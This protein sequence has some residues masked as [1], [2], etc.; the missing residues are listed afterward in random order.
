M[1]NDLAD[2]DS[3]L[4]LL[5]DAGYLSCDVGVGVDGLI[6]ELG[7]PLLKSSIIF[8]LVIGIILS[9]AFSG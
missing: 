6:I 2:V 7:L 3:N 4:C 8:E 5:D 9:R 1:S